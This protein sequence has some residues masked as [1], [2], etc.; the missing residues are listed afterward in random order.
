MQHNISLEEILSEEFSPKTINDIS[1]QF[2]YQP[3]RASAPNWAFIQKALTEN[4]GNK[5][6]AAKSLKISRGCLCYQIKKHELQDWDSC[7]KLVERSSA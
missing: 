1:E 6:R 5:C 2:T 3:K 4:K 7:E